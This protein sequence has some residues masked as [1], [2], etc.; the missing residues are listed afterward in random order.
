MK[1][2]LIKPDAISTEKIHELETVSKIHPSIAAIDLSMVKMKMKDA[3]EGVG[4]S[5]QQCESAEVEYKRFLHLNLIHPKA[6]IVPNKIMDTMWHYHILD[7]R[8][9]HKDSEKVFGGYFHHYPYFGMRGENDKKNLM[10][11]FEQTKM[12][13]EMAFGEPL[14]REEHSDC[15]HDCESRCWHACSNE[16]DRR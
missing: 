4:W 12:L 8:A 1:T 7:T 15:W 9:Y 14:V 10:N 5:V 16:D 13:Y 6:S 2:T 11:A 3:A